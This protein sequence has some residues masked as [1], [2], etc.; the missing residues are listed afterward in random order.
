M[1]T[2][3]NIYFLQHGNMSS[4]RSST[5]STKTKYMDVLTVRNSQGTTGKDRAPHAQLLVEPVVLPDMTHLSVDDTLEVHE[6]C[7]FYPT[8]QKNCN[9][10]RTME[11]MVRKVNAKD[12][13]T[14]R[15]TN[16]IPMAKPHPTYILDPEMPLQPLCYTRSL[17]GRRANDEIK[18]MLQTKQ[19]QE[20]MLRTTVTAEF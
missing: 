8:G 4:M 17:K 19:I 6:S 1:I 20:R 14:K 18:D 3:Y 15:N 16:S 7:V 10:R 2:F 9:M 11:E 12:N 5:R 13:F